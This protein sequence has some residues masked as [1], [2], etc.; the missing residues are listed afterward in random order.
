MRI[1]NTMNHTLFPPSLK[2]LQVEDAIKDQCYRLCIN[3]IFQYIR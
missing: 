3:N 1:Y 2:L